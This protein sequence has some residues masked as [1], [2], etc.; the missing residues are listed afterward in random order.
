MFFL[1][2]LYSVVLVLLAMIQFSGHGGFTQ[3][4]GAFTVTGRYGTVEAGA[5]ALSSGETLLSGAA[6]IYYGGMEFC[7]GEV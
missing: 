1:L 5:P 3:R 2:L 7:L 4:V 6:S